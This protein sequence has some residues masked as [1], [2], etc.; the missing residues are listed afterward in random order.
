MLGAIIGDIVGSRFEWNNYRAKD[1]EFFT[2]KCFPT[3]DSIMSLGVA[4]AII[5]S[6]ADY[7]DLSNNAIK[8]MREVGQPYP[9][10]GYGGGFRKWMYSD[11]PRPY[12]SYGNGAAMRV[13]ACGFAAKDIEHAKILSNMVTC[14]THNH[15]EG[16]K[17][18][19]ATAVAIWLARDGKN[20]L[21]IQDYI[22]KHYYPMNFT[23]DGI[24][25]TYQFHETCQGTVPQALMAFFES[26]DFED[27]IRN[28]ISIGGDSDTLAA[29]TG[30][31]AEAYYGI[32]AD[33]R[34]HALTFLDERLLG[35]LV[36]FEN[37]Y[38]YKIE[39][40]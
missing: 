17:G 5:E 8:Y 33:I 12:N 37:K 13:S 3:D 19:E 35:I 22:N 23:L 2:Y 14:V 29:I 27:A 38:P 32:P 20:I 6:K 26:T 16:L 25:A 31:V 24:R 30:G 39:E 9:D 7:S 34:M 36:D 40:V 11:N 28:A 1:F 21:E 18:A 10:C 15:P 4:K